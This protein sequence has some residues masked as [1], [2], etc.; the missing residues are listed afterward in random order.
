MRVMLHIGG[1]QEQHGKIMR[2]LRVFGKGRFETMDCNSYSYAPSMLD[3]D[4]EY[5]ERYENDDMQA[6]LECMGNVYSV[7]AMSYDGELDVAEEFTS[8][9]AATSLYEYIVENY[10]DTPP[11]DELQDFIRNLLYVGR[12]VS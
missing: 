12:Y 7:W 11:G 5:I 1:Q 2:V 3:G 6:E 8:L 4:R 10:S 9:S